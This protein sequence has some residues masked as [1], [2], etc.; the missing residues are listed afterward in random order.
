MSWWV[1][2]EFIVAL[3]C[4]GANAGLTLG[5]IEDVV[6]KAC[7]TSVCPKTSVQVR[8]PTAPRHCSTSMQLTPLGA[9]RHEV[10]IHLPTPASAP[11]L[12]APA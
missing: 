10:R 7:P 2:L 8:R 4:R 1:V 9:V 3:L 5:R 11:A 6:L 12:P